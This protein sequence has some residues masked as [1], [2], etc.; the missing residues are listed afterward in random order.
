[1]TNIDQLRAALATVQDPDLHK[2]LVTLNMV[3]NLAIDGATARFDLVLTTPSCPMK[4]HLI[5]ACRAAALTVP[6]ITS[7]EIA[8]SAEIPAARKQGV[9]IPGIKH[10]IAVS[11]GKGGV[12]KS[13]VCAN[14][15]VALAQ[16]GHKVGILDADFLGP[17]IPALLG[18]EH[19][20]V[21]SGAQLQA[22]EHHGVKAMSIGLLIPSGQAVIWRG[23]MLASALKQLLTEV[24]WGELDYLLVDLPPGTGDVQLNLA[25][26]TSLS[27]ALIVTTSQKL[28]L[29]SVHRGITMWEKVEVPIL[30][31]IENMAGHACGNCGHISP[32]FGEG[33]AQNLATGLGIPYLGGIPLDDALSRATDQGIPVVEAAPKAV[34]SQ[35]LK[36][37]AGEVAR[38]VS[39]SSLG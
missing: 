33:G 35:A 19:L 26:M 17:S 6:G 3:R 36:R 25:Q 7:A 18:L 29:D 4:Q 30:G 31:L 23:P 39:M 20:P 5:D 1:M 12:G 8:V 15:A 27:G 28:A 34:S 21:P 11:S 24:A 14:L 10:V 32:I 22:L 16:E 38:R 37:L 13:T 2:D 9:H